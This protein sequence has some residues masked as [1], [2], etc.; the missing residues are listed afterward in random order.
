MTYL[1]R[2]C[3][4]LFISTAILFAQDYRK[5]ISKKPNDFNNSMITGTSGDAVNS[6][7]SESFEDL[8]FPPT[9]WLKIS[10]DAGTGWERQ[11][12]GTTPFPGWNGG[13]VTAPPGG[14]NAVAFATWTTGGATYNDQWL[15]TPQITN[16]QSGDEISFWMWFPFSSYA[17]QVDLL[18]STTGTTPA[19]FNIVVEQFNLTVGSADTSWAQHTYQIT[20][21]VPAGSDIYIAWREHVLDNLNDGAI[22]C[23]DL[24]EV[25]SG[26]SSLITIAQAIE[27]LDNDFVPDRLGDTVTVQGVV[28]SPN[29]QTT[30][31]SYYISDG[32]AGTDIF[33]Y[34]PPLYTWAMGDEL[35]ITGVVTQYNGMSEIIPLDSTGWVLM[36]S[37]N[38][39]PDPAVLTLAQFKANA[40]LYEGSLVGFIGL[41]KVSG[42]WPASGSSVNLSLSDGVDTVV[43]RIDSD[44]DIDG[45]PEPSWPMDVIGIGSQFDNSVPYSGG[46][47]VFPRFYASDFL[48]AGSLPVELTSF[49]A[50]VSNSN[51]SLSWSTASET[52]NSGFQIERSNGSEYVSL[53][54]I[55]GHGTTTDIQNYS[56]VDQNVNAGKYTYRLKQVDFNGKFEYSNAV[57]VEV[58]GVKEFTLG[59]NYPN[60]FN[61]STTINFSLAVDSKVSL[62]IFDVLGQ[63]VATLLNGQLAAGN[64]PVSFDASSLNSGV[65]FYRIDASGVDGQKFSSTKKMILT[66]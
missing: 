4:F 27:D 46:Y 23:L 10:P 52:N 3:L 7:L 26:G 40:E 60:P 42:T 43:F 44:T 61:P 53:G 15:V 8:T 49:S 35:N 6:T 58:L 45:S 56:Y 20:N 11:T 16:V 25:T 1:V 41:N 59:Q 29:Y 18:I 36:S 37:G 19:D 34:A 57:E 30:N 14:D 28:F 21:F 5:D 62:K 50:N 9:G 12:A 51:V 38:P 39:T 66:K 64:H 47:Q 22:V 54:F 65:Y 55:A 2:I 17:D 33:M 24:V 31:N 32:T 63:E 13:T 48:P